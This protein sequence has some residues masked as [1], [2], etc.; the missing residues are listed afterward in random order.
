MKKFLIIA[1][2]GAALAAGVPAALAATDSRETP[3]ATFQPVQQQQP[4]RGDCPE[5]DGDTSATATPEI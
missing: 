1:A 5:K 2:A 3:A 4:D